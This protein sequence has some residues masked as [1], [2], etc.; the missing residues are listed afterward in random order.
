MFQVDPM[1]LVVAIGDSTFPEQEI[2]KKT[3]I[4]EYKGLHSL[5]YHC[6]CGDNLWILY[7]SL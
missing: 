4:A 2:G 1:C 5:T 3:K 7:Y 6:K